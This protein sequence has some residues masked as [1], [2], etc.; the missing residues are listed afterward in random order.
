MLMSLQ[1]DHSSAKASGQIRLALCRVIIA[2]LLVLTKVGFLKRT[3]LKG[4]SLGF[5]LDGIDGMDLRSEGYN[6]NLL[7]IYRYNELN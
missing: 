3:P 1:Q 4:V 7:I 6:H 2:I 5:I